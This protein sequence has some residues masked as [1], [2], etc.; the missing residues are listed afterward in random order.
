MPGPDSRPCL[1]WGLAWEGS[2]RVVDA[3]AQA[4]CPPSPPAT[5]IERVAGS[6][7]VGLAWGAEGEVGWPG[8]WLSGRG[9]SAPGQFSCPWGGLAGGQWGLARDVLAWRGVGRSASVLAVAL[10]LAMRY[11]I[12]RCE[13]QGA[14]P[15]AKGWVC[16][17]WGLAP[18]CDL[19]LTSFP[20]D[21]GFAAEGTHREPAELI[22]GEGV[23]PVP[24]LPLKPTVGLE[25]TLASAA[26]ALQSCKVRPS[27]QNCKAEASF[28][29]GGEAAITDTQHEGGEAERRSRRR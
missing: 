17:R 22:L 3:K 19:R 10:C 5:A 29:F 14:L 13:G 18:A 28:A 1:A 15:A 6:G 8:R 12:I 9:A 20:A 7:M 2:C 24:P 26:R 11:K 25:S 23:L 4:P 21:S 16:G 27:L